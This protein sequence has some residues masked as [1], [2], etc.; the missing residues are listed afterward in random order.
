MTTLVFWALQKVFEY[1]FYDCYYKICKE[2]KNEELRE[3]RTRKAVTNMY[4]F[5]YFIFSISFGWYT[6]K[7]SV[8]LP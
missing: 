1:S 3:M 2:K 4:K 7:D 8:I 5:T 6:L